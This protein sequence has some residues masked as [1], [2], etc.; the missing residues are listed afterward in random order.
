MLL[1]RINVAGALEGFERIIHMIRLLII[2]SSHRYGPL[3]T[4]NVNTKVQFN[5]ELCSN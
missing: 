1:I 4:N 2:F 3:C 5:S